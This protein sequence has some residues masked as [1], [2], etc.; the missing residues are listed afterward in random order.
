[1]KKIP[2]VVYQ[3]AISVSS[4]VDRIEKMLNEHNISIF[5]RINHAKAAQN[6]GLEMQPEEVLI[7]GNPSVGT[8]L[9]LENAAIGI[10]LP[11][12]IVVWSDNQVTYI[13]YQDLHEIA[14]RYHI[15]QNLMTIQKLSDFLEHLI[16][17]IIN[18]K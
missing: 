3:S 11:L 17:S 12:K 14:H 8:A 9:M 5:A 15:Q 7:F 10:E 6:V 16:K 2:L 1:M 13:A 4:V 18:I